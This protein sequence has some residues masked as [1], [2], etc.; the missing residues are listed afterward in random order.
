MRR[1]VARLAMVALVGCAGLGGPELDPSEHVRGEHTRLVQEPLDRLWPA[2]VAA[3][4]DEGLGPARVDRG[5]GTITTRPRRYTERDLRKKLAEIGDLSH[6]Q[7]TGLGSISEFVVTYH[8]L[9]T[10]AGESGTSL[11]IRSAIDAIARSEA[12]FLGPG[13]FTI[14]PHHIAIPSRGVVER[15][16]MRRLAESLFTTEEMLYLLGE[17]GVD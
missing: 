15:E 11:K 3:L 2:V 13:V 14:V 10:S 9:L 16:L 7:G 1:A 6:A 4:D 8:L 12:L 17:P 5:R